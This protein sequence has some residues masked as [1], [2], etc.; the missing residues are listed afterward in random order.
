[1]MRRLRYWTSI[2]LE[3]ST[4]SHASSRVT[5]RITLSP[6]SSGH[7]R[8][9]CS[10]KEK[11]GQRVD[12]TEHGWE[13][14][15]LTLRATLFYH[16]EVCREYNQ[17]QGG[18]GGGGYTPC[19]SGH[20]RCPCCHQQQVCTVYIQSSTHGGARVNA[21]YNPYSHQQVCTEFNQARRGGGG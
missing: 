15:G 13:G 11:G 5:S 1:M 9:P 6:N 4:T 17:A 21:S 19:S 2:L 3:S 10:H 18:G 7:A 8:C 12:T 16:R 20:A 14:G